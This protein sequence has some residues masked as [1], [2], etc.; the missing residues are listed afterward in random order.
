MAAFVFFRNP[1]SH[2]N[3]SRLKN[4]AT[5]VALRLSG[6]QFFPVGDPRPGLRPYHDAFDQ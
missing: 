4:V 3:S 5:E 2:S 1:G 6:Q